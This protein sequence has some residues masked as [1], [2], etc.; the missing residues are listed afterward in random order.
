MRKKAKIPT[1]LIHE[2]NYLTSHLRY[3]NE[4]DEDPFEGQDELHLV[5]E[6]TGR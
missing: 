1:N 6:D 3:I 5:Q 2:F 4:F